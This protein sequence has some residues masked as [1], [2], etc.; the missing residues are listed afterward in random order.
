MKLRENQHSLF[1]T[2][3][4]LFA[5][6]WILIYEFLDHTISNPHIRAVTFQLLPT[7]SMFVGM[8]LGYKVAT[9]QYR[10]K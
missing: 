1:L 4:A 10:G 5:L 3:F 6:L 9:F 2:T 7:I 8:W